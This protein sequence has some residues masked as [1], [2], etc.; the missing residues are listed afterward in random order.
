MREWM[1]SAMASSLICERCG[2][3]ART[4]YRGIPLCPSCKAGVQA[5]MRAEDHQRSLDK[6]P[7][8]DRLALEGESAPDPVLDAEVAELQRSGELPTA[9][10]LNERDLM[11]LMRP[12]R[13]GGLVQRGVASIEADEIAGDRTSFADRSK[14]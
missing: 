3:E 9:A 7:D 8:L 13:A 10:G 2:G 12:T 5:Q 14:E 1:G 4:I 6:F 11:D